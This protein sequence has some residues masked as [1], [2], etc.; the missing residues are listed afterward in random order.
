M[1]LENK[2]ILVTGS[3]TG[4]GKAIAKACLDEGAEVLIHGL[5]ADLAE[6]T[7]AE[8]D[9]ER[10]RSDVLIADITDPGAGKKIVDAAIAR[11]GKIDGLVNN[12]AA[13]GTGNIRDTDEAKWDKFLDTNA[14]APFF[15]IQAALPHL[16]DS[17]GCVVNIG[18]V[19]AH[20][21]EPD[22]LPYSISKGALQTMTRNLGDT[23]HREFGVRVNQINPGWILTEN[24]R[25]RK[26]EQGLPEDWPKQL[27]DFFAPSGRIFQPEEIAAAAVYFLGNE[28]GPVSGAILEIEQYPMIG[29]N[30]PKEVG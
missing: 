17:H 14:K 30:P 21:G 13:V 2:T 9:P 18:S 11:F 8:L 19:N 23:L 5:E 25:Q 20:C 28:S 6:Q 15:L 12:A 7:W 29:R 3:T 1:R 26:Q 16:E 24:E 4:I 10:N 27:G 22:L